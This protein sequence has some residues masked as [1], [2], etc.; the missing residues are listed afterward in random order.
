MDVVVGAHLD[1]D[2]ALDAVRAADPADDHV[3]P[4]ACPPAT[5]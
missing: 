1:R 4:G 2:L 5:G 3:H